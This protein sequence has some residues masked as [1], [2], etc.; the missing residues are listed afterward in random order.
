MFR[1]LA[2]KVITHCAILFIFDIE[3]LPLLCF[4]EIVENGGYLDFMIEEIKKELNIISCLLS[5]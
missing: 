3:H 2:S 1:L 4:I 5:E